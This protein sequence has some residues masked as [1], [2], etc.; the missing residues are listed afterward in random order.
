MA[1]S[2]SLI[3]KVISHYRIIEKLGCGMGVVYKAED[4]RLHRPVALKFLSPEMLHDAAALE[5]FRREAQPAF[6]EQL[7]KSISATFVVVAGNAFK[8]CAFMS[9]AVVSSDGIQFGIPPLRGTA[10]RAS[11][12]KSTSPVAGTE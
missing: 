7:L 3:G 12:V 9:F 1:D 11:T 5:R 10:A 8:G 2:D 6:Q 4:T